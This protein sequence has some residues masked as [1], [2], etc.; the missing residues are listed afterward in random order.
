MILALT[1]RTPIVTL[2]AMWV[3]DIS[4]AKAM[5]GFVVRRA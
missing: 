2:T 3:Y 5:K 1:P 4:G